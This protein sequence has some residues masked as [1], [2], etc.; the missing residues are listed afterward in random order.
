MGSQTART[1]VLIVEDHRLVAQGLQLLL[2][3]E[4]DMQVVGLTTAY[5]EAVDLARTS[6]PDVL[7]VDYRLQDSSG[8]AV[9]RAVAACVPSVRTLFLSMSVNPMFLLEA[10]RSGARAYV[11]KTQAADDL[12]DAVR[13]VAAG[14]ML[15]PA[16][17]LADLLRQE[18]SGH[19]PLG[20]LT[21]REQELLQMLAEGLD[22]HSIADRLG[23]SYVTVRGHLRNVLSKLNAHSRL[24]AVARAVELGLVER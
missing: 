15:I 12:V 24:E 9:A 2:A 1:K 6:E 20:Q 23:I 3:A 8:P 17:V 10:V 7:L 21:G 5:E 19:Q 22:N 14:E 13:R 11:L 16:S 18:H 4:P